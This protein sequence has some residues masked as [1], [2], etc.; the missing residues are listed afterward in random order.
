MA[1]LWASADDPWCLLL[2]QEALQLAGPFDRG[3]GVVRLVERR[4]CDMVVV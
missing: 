1:L 4:G 3:L 2:L